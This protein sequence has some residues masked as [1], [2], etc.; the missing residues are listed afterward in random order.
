MNEDKYCVLMTREYVCR[1]IIVGC[2]LVLSPLLVCIL[3]IETSFLMK[4]SDANAVARPAIVS[5]LRE[6]FWRNLYDGHWDGALYSQR[7]IVA[8][9]PLPDRLDYFRVVLQEGGLDNYR[10]HI[11]IDAVGDD[12]EAL[13]QSLIA[14]KTDSRYHKLSPEQQGEIDDRIDTLKHFIQN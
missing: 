13:Y 6:K 11:F 10:I 5:F 14:F 8:K 4:A 7:E 2:L 12:A 3:F 1:S 9:L